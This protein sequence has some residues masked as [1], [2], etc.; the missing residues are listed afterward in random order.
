[1][2]VAGVSPSEV[3]LVLVASSAGMAVKSTIG[4][5]YPLIA[6]PILATATGLENAVVVVALPTAAS[7]ILLAW[8]S[9]GALSDTSNLGLLAATAAAGAIVG[10]FVL[11][12][13][14]EEPLILLIIVSVAVYGARVLWFKDL[15]VSAVAAR[16]A[17][18]AVGVAAGLLQGVLGMP[19]PLLASW[20]HACRVPRDA[21]ILSLT[22]LFLLSGIGQI[23]AQ[24][25]VGAYDRQRLIA[26]AVA[27][28]PVIA[29][30]PL[31]ESWRRRLSDEAF[32]RTVL[33]VLAAATLLLM[34]RVVT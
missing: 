9:R 19:G 33:A 18:P 26:A 15:S 30:T 10:T 16:R 1:M 31:G 13:V 23:S 12:S 24:V 6:I 5:G 4:I 3:I 2:A 22:T 17:T 34:L 14:P 27:L 29:L 11:V 25:T 21:Y 32:D 7:N 8:R 28:G 20:L